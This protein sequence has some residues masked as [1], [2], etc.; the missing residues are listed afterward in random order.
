MSMRKSLAVD[1]T[2]TLD[3]NGSTQRIRM[4][5]KRTGLPPLVIVQAGPGLPVLNEVTKFQQRLRLEQQF[6][7]AYWEQR[8]CGAASRAD[9]MSASLQQQVDDLRQVLRWLRDETKQTA[10][11]FGISLGA[12]IALRAV[13]HEPACVKSVVAISVDTHTVWSDEAAAAFLE[14]QAVRAGSRRLSR[15]LRALEK[16]PYLD[17]AAIQRRAR[18]L[19][20]LGTIE[21]GKTFNALFRE[22]LFSMI[23]TYGVVGAGKTLRNISLV[24]RTMLPELVA[25][26]LFAAPPRLMVPVHCVFGE[27]DALL[28]ATVVKDLPSAIIAPA[29]TVRLVPNAGHMV[30]FDQP[31]IV[32]SIAVNA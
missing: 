21:R 13:E 5:A 10:V 3:V 16:P 25:L 26:D 17:P 8:G 23:R 12:T 11:V 31:D 15:R 29:C 9:A 14:E 4:C 18:L 30:H 7:V 1:T 22:A 27:Q 2:I 6:L 20:D 32:R 19:A 28:P 24:Q